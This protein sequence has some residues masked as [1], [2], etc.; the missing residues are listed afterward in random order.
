[1]RRFLLIILALG[2]WHLALSTCKAQPNVDIWW[3]PANKADTVMDFGVTLEGDPV[4]VNFS[5]VNRN[6]YT[7]A[8]F[9]SR[10]DAE[11]Y[12]QIVNTPDVPSGDPRKEE[13]K[14]ANTLP[15]FVAPG[16]TGRFGVLFRSIQGDLQFPPDVVT[17]ALLQLRVVDST[18]PLSAS[19]NKT[20]LLRALKTNEILASNTPFLRFDSVYVQPVPLPPEKRY[21]VTNVTMVTIPIDTQYLQMQ[22]SV[23]GEPEIEV[24][25]LPPGSKFGPR[26]QLS[27]LVRYLPRDMGRDSGDFNVLYKPNPD[28]EPDTIVAHISGL[29]VLQTLRVV[30]APSDRGNVTVR[31]DTIDYGDVDADGTGGVVARIEIRNEGNINAFVLSE[32]EVGTPRETNA[33]EVLRDLNNN[34]Q[35]I[36]TNEVD[37]LVVR[38]NPVDGGLHSMRYDIETNLRSRPIFGIPDGAQT[39]RLYFRA[40]AR[41]PQ[42][43]IAPPS[44]S[45]GTVVFL[46]NCPSASKRSIVVRNVGT[47]PLRIDSI[48]VS[49][50]NAPLYV[51]QQTFSPIGVAESDT[52]EVLYIPNS[53]SV[54]NAR[55]V[56]Y[57]NA[58]GIPYE[59]PAIGESV[60]ADTITV[61]L[62][63]DIRARPG[64]PI[65]VSVTV[66]SN[67]VVRTETAH[68]ELAFDPSLLRYRRAVLVGTASEGAAI[69][70]SENP[71]GLLKIDL[72]A[73]GSFS[74]RSSLILLEFDTF[75]GD[76]AETELALSP[77]TTRF[78]NAGCESVLDVST[79]N[80]KFLI[81][82][83]C[84]LE[85]KTSTSLRSIIDIGIAPNPVE[86]VARI[87]ILSPDSSTARLS[88]TDASG[89]V[90]VPQQTE[91]LVAGLNIVNL[92]LAH[93]NPGLY[94]IEFVSGRIRRVVP[95]MVQR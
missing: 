55:L 69:S 18:S 63:A 92:N 16:D 44:L 25:T 57:T 91:M 31:G 11:P 65:S 83:V 66:D 53:V 30:R 23:V 27:W 38:F 8:I 84:G 56:F 62:P 47:I 49:P 82:S 93:I 24:T 45:F 34:E 36:E 33:F 17:E 46:E 79:R 9:S 10:P 4:T 14:E 73:N 67:R 51:Q 22:T 12:Y 3:N 77:L 6:S 81:D 41:K 32:T 90:V 28:V 72:D 29:G 71:S 35:Q 74:N 85:Y 95:L 21:S 70:D 58:F 13:F 61:S 59:I 86:D 80:G 26:G 94:F 19:R 50:V 20:F 68:L 54:L 48:V 87:I 89:S 78:G 37:T 42:M 76:R 7:V 88:L 52:I 2:S 40:F 64:N 39:K 5:V 1:M 15:Y 43:Q 75:L 60:P